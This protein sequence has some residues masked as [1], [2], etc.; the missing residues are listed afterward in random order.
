MRGSLCFVMSSCQDI[1][2]KKCILCGYREYVL[3]E[4][5]IFMA[6]REFRIERGDAHPRY[7]RYSASHDVANSKGEGV[8]S[9]FVSR[10]RCRRDEG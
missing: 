5:V 3:S 1:M 7:S 4:S 6:F 9:E 8:L 10:Y 2:S